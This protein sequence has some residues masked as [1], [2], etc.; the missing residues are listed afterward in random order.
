MS[1][2]TWSDSIH[3]DIKGTCQ[4]SQR[5]FISYSCSYIVYAKLHP[6][7]CID[8]DDT[9]NRDWGDRNRDQRDINH[10]RKDLNRYRPDLCRDEKNDTADICKGRADIR[11]DG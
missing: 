11:N 2:S 10:A 4:Q 7:G 6:S 9:T 8:N 5:S 3:S 1:L